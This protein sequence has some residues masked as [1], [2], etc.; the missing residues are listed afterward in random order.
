MV[1]I[2]CGS[3]GLGHQIG[4]EFLKRM[5]IAAP[6]HGVELPDRELACAPIASP[7]G[8]RIPRRDARRDQLRAGQPPDT[9]PPDARECLKQY[10]PQARLPLLYDVS[11]NTC[12]V[13]EHEV[14]GRRN[15]SCTCIARARR[16]HSGRAIPTCRII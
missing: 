2:H 13:E 11:H 8:K 5:V 9:H 15:A 7:L 14:G 16:A 1:S 4:T 3:R 6:G 12:K 10:L